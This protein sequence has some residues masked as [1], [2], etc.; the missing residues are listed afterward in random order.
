MEETVQSSNDLPEHPLMHFKGWMDWM[1]ACKNMD[2]GSFV[3]RFS[4][5][6]VP[7]EYTRS[8]HSANNAEGALAK[9]DS[10]GNK[11]RLTKVSGA[12]E[13]LSE[14]VTSPADNPGACATAEPDKPSGAMIYLPAKEIAEQMHCYPR[15]AKK[16]RTFHQPGVL[17]E[18]QALEQASG[19]ATS[20]WRA[21]RFNS[22]CVADLTMGLGVDS[23][24]WAQAGSRVISC[25][26]NRELASIARYNHKILGLAP[27]IS[28]Y[29]KGAIKWLRE[30]TEQTSD[31]PDLYY[32]DPSRRRGS[33]RVFLLEQCEPNVFTV[34]RYIRELKGTWLLKLSPL[35]DLTYLQR[36]LDDCFEL[37]VVS[38]LG[39]VKE[40]LAFG[41]Q[42]FLSAGMRR[43]AKAVIHAV[44]LDE[45]GN[46]RFELSSDPDSARNVEQAVADGPVVPGQLIL[47]PD[48]AIVKAGLIDT[49]ARQYGMASVHPRTRYLV[50][51]RKK[52]GMP[53]RW[54]KIEQVHAYKPRHLVRNLAEQ[55]IQK[56]RIHESGFPV[57]AE[58]LYKVLRCE[59][60]EQADLLA[61]R[62]ATGELLLLVARRL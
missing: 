17:Y 39:E 59:M 44:M 49:L 23:L 16:L 51:N 9:P 4:G 30:L 32:A 41:G 19:F 5:K 43:S 48:P 35:I 20:T 13:S 31:K 47:D 62:G 18:K 60:G 10:Y 58:K 50:S 34:L 7:A 27:C 28:G 2:P 40:V 57:S 3:L 6:K 29:H 21:R 45:M 8:M 46:E 14:K 12:V 24:A 15:A 25:E 61:A 36:H 1:D 38:V 33:E 56:V 55:G 42:A 26:Q 52:R 54:Y 37:Y 22:R 53:G 11:T